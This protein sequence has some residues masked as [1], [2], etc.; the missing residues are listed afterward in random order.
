MLGGW[1]G[2][3]EEEEEGKGLSKM[4]Q[5]KGMKETL[6]QGEQ[7]SKSTH[8][9]SSVYFTTNQRFCPLCT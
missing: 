6:K 3:K 2:I 5:G 1:E 8:A 9:L 4:V 7:Q